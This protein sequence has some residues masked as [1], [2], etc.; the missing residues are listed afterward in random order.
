VGYG[1]WTCRRSA[2]RIGLNRRGPQRLTFTPVGARG[3]W[4]N[5]LAH[6]GWSRKRCEPRRLVVKTDKFSS[7]RII[8]QN[9]LKNIKKFKKMCHHEQIERYRYIDGPPVI[10][11]RP[12][13]L[14]CTWA[15]VRCR[16]VKTPGWTCVSNHENGITICMI[17]S[18]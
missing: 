8:L 10:G 7:G 18:P 17:R 11:L 2:R 13:I 1:G 6:G 5:R 16:H 14:E 3:C 4:P 15:F 12:V 9:D